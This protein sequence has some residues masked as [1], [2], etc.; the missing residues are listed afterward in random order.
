M[1]KKLLLLLLATAFTVSASAGASSTRPTR[2]VDNKDVKFKVEKGS[3]L[4]N[5]MYKRGSQQTL[6]TT[7]LN[8][9]DWNRLAPASHV[10]RNGNS[11]TWDFEDEDQYLE[12]T[13][14]DADGDGHC[15]EYANT[16]GQ[17]THSGT[18]VVSSASYDNET[19]SALTPDNWLISPMVILQG[20]L[21]F[22]ACGQDPSFARETFAVYLAVGNPVGTEEFIKI[23]P[24]ITVTSSMKEHIIDLSEYQGQEGC[25]AFRHYKS[26]DQFRLN[27]DDVTITTDEVIPEPGPDVPEVITEIPQRCQVNTYYRNSGTIL[28]HWLIGIYA[29]PTAG[30]FKL[31]FDPENND[32]YI[33][34]P[35]WVYN[36]L[37]TWIKG[38]IDPT[39]GIITIPTGQYLYWNEESEHGMQVVMGSSYVYLNGEDPNTGEPQYYMG[40]E[41][42]ERTTEFYMKVDGDNVY[43]LDTQGNIYSPYP[44]W[45]NAYG[46][47][48]IWNDSKIW[49]AIEFA[50]H[51]RIS[52]EE[53]PF[54]DLAIIVP[55]VPANPTADEFYDSGK[56]NGDTRFYF[57][58][59]EVDIDGNK[60][61]FELLSYSMWVDN[62]N[63]PEIFVFDENTYIDLTGLGDLTEIPYSI[64]YGGYDFYDYMFYLYRTNAPGYEPL[65]TNNIGIQAHYTVPNESGQL[66]KNSSEI[67][68]LYDQGSN[69]NELN[70]GKTIASVR[71]YNVTGQEMAQPSG[72]TIQVT[73]YSDGTTSATKVIK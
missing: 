52:G 63:G 30:K 53:L 72:M 19:E 66:I 8:A 11:I 28:E 3:T 5:K 55:A 13:M 23:S 44:E 4:I 29:R 48:L 59:P 37:D 50:N 17:T 56:E 70:T 58:L 51:D 26:T 39:T 67:V 43:L 64:F 9:M 61:D 49:E 27:I 57:T 7:P 1:M 10:L 24:D 2:I 45:G 20:K 65:F 54:G 69:V 33:Q 73:T 34:N 36:T 25:I 38:T 41:I 46:L 42:D 35:I 12:W 32:V 15:W 62:G 22:Y 6:S 71:Y 31:A 40:T 21:V 14:I 47:M 68:W 16:E 60:I 18:G